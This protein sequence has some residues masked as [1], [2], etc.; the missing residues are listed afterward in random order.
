MIKLCKKQKFTNL[1]FVCSI[2]SILKYRVNGEQSGGTMMQEGN[3]NYVI[4]DIIFSQKNLGFSRIIHDLDKVMFR[5]LTDRLDVLDISHIQAL[6]IIY[7]MKNKEKDNYQKEIETT[8][9]LTNPTLTVSIKSME[10]KDLIIRKKSMKDGRYYNLNLT[11]K[12]ESLYESCCDIYISIQKE[13]EKILS[14]E[15]E[16]KFREIAEKIMN[17]FKYL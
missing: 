14:K 4:D 1:L 5:Y 2:H 9:G 13:F 10:K 3:T 16:E 12:G 8:F 15:E 17:H 7:L 11:S 6:V